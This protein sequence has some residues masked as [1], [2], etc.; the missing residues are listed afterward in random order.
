[1]FW[2][3]KNLE[4]SFESED[5]QNLALFFGILEFSNIKTIWRTVLGFWKLFNE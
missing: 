3:N 5:F 4:K 2:R 1:M